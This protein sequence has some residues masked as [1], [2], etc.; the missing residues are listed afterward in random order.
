[1]IIDDLEKVKFKS[2]FTCFFRT[3]N[4]VKINAIHI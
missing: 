3:V 1:M 2:V 4:G